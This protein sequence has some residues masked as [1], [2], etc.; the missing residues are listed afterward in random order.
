MWQNTV[1][2][3]LAS[4]LDLTVNSLE[5][6]LAFGI[7]AL[8]VYITYKILNFPDLTVDG[9]FPLGAAVAASM[10]IKGSSPLMATLMATVMGAVAGCVTGLL[11]T[12]AKI[13][14]LLSGILTMTALYSINLRI[15][16]RPNI[17]LL[18]QPTLFTGLE[19]TIKNLW[20]VFPCQIL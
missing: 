14:H 1:L 16:G 3:A 18:N 6:G 5:Q 10:I 4:G 13:S 20:P 11:S 19:E 7:M 17:A 15:M 12:K 9:S 2:T 8:G